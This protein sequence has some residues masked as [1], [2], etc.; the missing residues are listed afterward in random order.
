LG[1]HE[2]A[3]DAISQAVQLYRQLADARPDAFL[4]ELASAL[5]NQAASFSG[6]ER[7]EEAL[8]AINQ[9]VQLYRQLATVRPEEFSLKLAASSAINGII[10]RYNDR[11][12][13]AVRLE[14]QSLVISEMLGQKELTNALKV[15]LQRTYARD[16]ELVVS[17]WRE[18]AGVAPPSWL[19][20]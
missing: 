9:A 10:Y 4:P 13:E 18:V 19:S 3:L 11:P 17:A 20:A 16:A 1:R 5:H 8:D 6:L 12:D 15:S 7:P 2:E 14:I